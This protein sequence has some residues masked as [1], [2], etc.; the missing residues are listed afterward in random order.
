MIARITRRETLTT[1]LHGDALLVLPWEEGQ[2]ME[3]SASDEGETAAAAHG[4][5]SETALRTWLA[6]HKWSH[7]PPRRPRSF[8][9]SQL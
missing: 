7:S 8:S 2:R 5:S 6:C 3:Y 1:R 4:T 9:G